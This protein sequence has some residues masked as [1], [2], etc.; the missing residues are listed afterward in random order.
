LDPGGKKAPDPGSGSAT[1]VPVL[2]I[3]RFEIKK[4]RKIYTFHLK[5]YKCFGSA[6]TKCRSG[7][8]FE[9]ECGYG[10]WRYVKNKDFVKIK[11]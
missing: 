3:G 9:N 6:L 1:L 10:S 2:L 5:P 11:K 7:S 8:S 4:T